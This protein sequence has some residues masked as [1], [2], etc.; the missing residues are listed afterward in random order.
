MSGI[1]GYQGE[2]EPELLARMSAAIAHR[3]PDGE[4]STILAPEGGAPPVGLAHRRLAVLDL[5]PEA[6]QPLSVRCARCRD[7]EGGALV[8]VVDGEI[9]N[10]RELRGELERQGHLLRTGSDAEVLLHLYA[11]QGPGLLSRLHGS[12]ALAI[13]D[14]RTEGL[15]EGIR[16]GDLFLARDGL[17]IKP[18]Y[19]AETD[20]G[21]LFASELKA[22][23]RYPNLSRELDYAA[24][25]QNLAYL[26]TPAPRTMLRGVRKMRPGFALL[27]RNGRVHREWC[28]YDLPYGREPRKTG[29]EELAEEVRVRL[30]AA[31][32]R[33]MEA[34]VPVGAF[35]SGG[36]DS[37]AVVA[38]MRRIRPE[39]RPRCYCI[40]FAGEESVD[41]TPA[42]IPF[43]RQAARELDVDLQILEVEPD[44]ILHLE[45]MLY[46]LDEPQADPAPINALL[47][48]E[49]AR[50]DGIGVL[51]SGAGGDDI[52]SG[53][54]RHRALHLERLWSGLPRGARALVAG[55]SRR[56][57]AGRGIG[58]MH[59]PWA[60]RLAKLFSHIDLDADRRLVSY[61][62]W[63]AEELRRGLYSPMLAAETAEL[64]TA[65][66]LLESLA[67]IPGEG[68]R[69]NRMLYLEGKHF[70]AD[71]NLNY[72]DRMGTSAGVE[73]RAPLLDR[74]LVDFATRIPPRLKQRGSEGKYIFKKALE[75]Y[76]PHAV[77]YRGKSGFGAPLRRWLRHELRERVE[78]LL[79]P[80]ALRSRGLFDPAAVRRLV[81]LDRE[82]RV[83]GSYTI[84]ALICIELW[85]RLLID[86][87]A[88]S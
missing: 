44:I 64:D 42:D 20:S 3:G 54:R 49:R 56:V 46:L 22:L 87:P 69:L 77:I 67:R 36:L 82:G 8:L 11:D 12:F 75:P 66:P 5:S 58:D 6:R 13:Y 53:Y 65:A 45:R 9:Y 28:H 30:E 85:C 15:P 81:D 16:T 32:S 48:A 70:L 26:W 88:G 79:S 14:G 25:H 37:S 34:A 38:M 57:A 40:G 41:G 39:E 62:W 74:E 50:R 47:I 60:R 19:H 29:E 21:F 27:V 72:G 24:L 52:F 18:L 1:A 17:G 61:F 63:S 35:L 71:H 2:F 78:E 7:P 73:I 59:S 31:V 10:F 76:L 33:Q 86:A 68:D 4:G 43:A 23:L 84:F 51:L 80:E 55:A 83:D